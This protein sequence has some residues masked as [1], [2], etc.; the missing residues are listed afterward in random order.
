MC[1]KRG[2]SGELRRRNEE[3]E[4]GGRRG[5]NAERL[6]GR[7]HEDLRRHNLALVVLMIGA[8]T[9][10]RRNHGIVAGEMRMHRLAVMM[11][12]VVVTEMHVRQ[13]SGYRS[14]LYEQD[15]HGGGQPAKHGAIVVNCPDTGT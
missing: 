8:G 2:A 14:G 7:G 9:R 11:I 6:A 5:R 10:I 1:N 15:E 3:H 12:P 4:R 13:R